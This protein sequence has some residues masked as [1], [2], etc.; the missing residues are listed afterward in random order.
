MAFIGTGTMGFPMAER[1]IRAGYSPLI[2]DQ[3]PQCVDALVELGGR[4]ASDLMQVS[5]RPML[6]SCRY[7]GQ[8]KCRKLSAANRV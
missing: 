6:Y 5:S 8:Y 7:R 4:R 3:N 2:Y 1:F